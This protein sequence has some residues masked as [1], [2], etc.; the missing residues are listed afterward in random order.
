[1]LLQ[2]MLACVTGLRLVGPWKFANGDPS[3]AV[4]L[5]EE[6]LG[7]GFSADSSAFQMLLDLES[8]D[9][10]IVRFMLGS[11]QG[12]E[13]KW[14]INYPCH[15]LASLET[16]KLFYLIEFFARLMYSTLMADFY[17]LPVTLQLPVFW[18]QRWSHNCRWYESIC[19]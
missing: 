8:D 10:I 4:R 13:M 11:S 16:F 15:I 2:T 12:R 1:M 17:P 9:K 5:I 6:M 18:H 19:V 7:R 3:N 14:I